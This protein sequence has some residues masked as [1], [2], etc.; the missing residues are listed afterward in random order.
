MANAMWALR[1]ARSPA[2]TQTDLGRLIGKDRRQVSH[3]ELGRY[4]PNLATAMD[5][6][7][8][9]G[10]TLEDIFFEE[11]KRSMERVARRIERRDEGSA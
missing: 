6:A 11:Y 9:L 8:A 1:R 4:L 10:A 5:I 3:Y 2:W 7:T